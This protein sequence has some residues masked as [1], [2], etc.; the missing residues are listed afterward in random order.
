MKDGNMILM[1]GNVPVAEIKLIGGIPVKY[2]DVYNEKEIPLPY[3][4]TDAPVFERE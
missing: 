4:E 2:L 3:K 1:H